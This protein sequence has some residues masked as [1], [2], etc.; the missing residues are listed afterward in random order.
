MPNCVGQGECW[1]NHSSDGARWRIISWIVPPGRCWYQC[2]IPQMV[3]YWI[4]ATTVAGMQVSCNAHFLLLLTAW[5]LWWQSP[6][7]MWSMI[8]CHPVLWRLICD[9]QYTGF[10]LKLPKDL[11]WE[12]CFRCMYYR[13]KLEAY[14]NLPLSMHIPTLKTSAEGINIVTMLSV[15][16]NCVPLQLLWVNI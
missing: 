7:P 14:P 12:I 1:G 3:Y 15:I 9:N 16:F 4:I 2:F 13:R 11:S 5:C 6:S 10:G 8:K